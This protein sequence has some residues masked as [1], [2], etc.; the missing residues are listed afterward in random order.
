ML[1]SD[2]GGAEVAVYQRD[3]GWQGASLAEQQVLVAAAAAV[4]GWEFRVSPDTDGD[5]RWRGVDD[6][7]GEE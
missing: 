2:N 7:H 4:G 5:G 6:D 3:H 1:D